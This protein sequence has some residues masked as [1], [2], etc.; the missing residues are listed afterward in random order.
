MLC[1]YIYIYAYANWKWN[2]VYRKR[3]KRFYSIFTASV[4]G[5]VVVNLCNT[6]TLLISHSM[7]VYIYTCMSRYY[8]LTMRIKN[9][10][11]WITSSCRWGS[12]PYIWLMLWKNIKTKALTLLR[13]LVLT[14]GL[15]YS[16]CHFVTHRTT[17][18][19]YMW[20][21]L[22]MCILVFEMGRSAEG[23]EFPDRLEGWDW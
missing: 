7:Y 8:E 19:L 2:D 4:V 20:K 6:A 1:L 23:S 18:K 5:K 22:S 12:S 14:T 13:Y 17:L 3:G 11:Q 15:P 21:V 16:G 10:D 9:Q